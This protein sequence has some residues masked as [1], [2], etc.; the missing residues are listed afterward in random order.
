MQ[1]FLW[2]LWMQKNTFWVSDFQ[3]LQRDEKKISRNFGLH[4]TL[5]WSWLEVECPSALVAWHAN[6]PAAFFVTLCKTRLRFDT[7]IPDAMSSF[8]S[9]PCKEKQKFFVI[10]HD[11]LTFGVLTSFLEGGVMKRKLLCLGVFIHNFLSPFLVSISFQTTQEKQAKSLGERCLTWNVISAVHVSPSFQ[12][13]FFLYM[14]TGLVYLRFPLASFSLADSHLFG[15]CENVSV[16]KW[17]KRFVDAQCTN[18]LMIFWLFVQGDKSGNQEIA[19]FF[20]IVNLV[21]QSRV[22]LITWLCHDQSGFIDYKS[23]HITGRSLIKMQKRKGNTAACHLELT[24][25]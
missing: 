25:A 16:R 4:L 11:E 3:V 1:K 5:S 13:A 20:W 24:C 12:W 9:K 19:Y 15:W 8:S 18:I 2:S 17:I 22:A 14:K 6:N 10:L 23:A 7:M 21:R